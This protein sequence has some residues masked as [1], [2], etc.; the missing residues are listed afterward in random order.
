MHYRKIALLVCLLSL[1]A[2]AQKD[3]KLRR[4]LQPACE[5]WPNEDVGYIIGGEERKAFSEPGT[6]DKHERV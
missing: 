1:S 6:D 2:Y 5:K 4:E 3:K